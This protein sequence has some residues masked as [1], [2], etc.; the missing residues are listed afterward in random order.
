ML[1]DDRWFYPSR[2]IFTSALLGGHCGCRRTKE[3]ED[4]E[5]EIQMRYQM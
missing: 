5:T 3:E 2:R 1:N 4:G